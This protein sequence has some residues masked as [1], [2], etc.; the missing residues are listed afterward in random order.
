[1]YCIGEGLVLLLMTIL[2]HLFF[3]T[4]NALYFIVAV[5]VSSTHAWTAQ[6]DHFDT[7]SKSS[8]VLYH[9]ELSHQI[10]SMCMPLPF[11]HFLN[12]SS[13]TQQPTQLLILYAAA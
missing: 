12:C 8:T 1:M 6:Q 9:T 11:R 2:S 5:K 10:D 4:K 7:G 13:S 3:V